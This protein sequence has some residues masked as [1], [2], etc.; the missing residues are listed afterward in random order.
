MTQVRDDIK[1][2]AEFAALIPP[3]SAEERQQLEDNIVEHGGARDPLVVWRFPP[4]G[5]SEDAQQ[6][7]DDGEQLEQ[8]SGDE[9]LQAAREQAGE[10]GRAYPDCSIVGRTQHWALVETAGHR[11]GDDQKYGSYRDYQWFCTHTGQ[12]CFDDDGS[13]LLDGH[14]RYE[15]CTRRVLPFDVCELCFDAREG[16]ADWMDRNQLGRRNLHPD[17]FTLLLGRRY[18]RAK[19]AAGAPDG[20]ANRS[21]NNVPNNGT[22]N[23]TAKRLGKEHGVS[24][25]TVR[26]A[27]KFAEAVAKAEQI[28][29]GIGLKVAHGQAPARAAVIKA[30]TL[31]EK[32]PDKAR[33]IIEGGKKMADVI[34]EEKR[35]EV[36]ASL[37][38][39]EARQAKELAGQ[40][41]VIVIDPPWPMEKIERDVRPN[42][43]AFDYPTMSEKQL[44]EMPMPAA[45]ACHLWLWTTHRF[46]PMSLRLLEAWGFKYVC[47][48][49]WHKPGGFQ[50]IGLP[51]YNCEFTVYARRGS[52][53]F[54]DTKAFPVCFVAPRGKHSEKPEAFY[55]VVRRV[56]AGRRIDIFNRR[57]I[58]GFDVWGKEA[59][60]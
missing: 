38:S 22:L 27:G 44:A 25:T 60:E 10:M 2:D 46:L 42:Q 41:D 17:A 52:P 50:P 58:E 13:I 21:S 16:A 1:I 56:T 15:I 3:L 48:F 49:V 40:Y 57:D 30:A 29:P 47:T 9:I 7:V 54:I 20:N 8:L 32:S 39:V 19:K 12:A 11:D 26:N 34:R 33:E 5:L 59:S 43:S 23:T 36:V 37:E 4:E 18:N 45:D 6:V 53:Q 14:N 55:D 28:S 51:Q 35:A 24:A 31:L